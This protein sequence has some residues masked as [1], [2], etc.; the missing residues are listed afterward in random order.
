MK[1]V[2]SI[3]VIV[4]LA[5]VAWL[6]LSNSHRPESQ[7]DQPKT[8]DDVSDSTKSDNAD[9]G[10]LDDFDKTSYSIDELDSIWLVVNKSRPIDLDYV[11]SDLR[12]VN[13]AH[14]AGKSDSEMSMRNVAAV[15]LEEMF[16]AASVDS[17]DLQLGSGYRSSELQNYYYT[18]YVQAYSQ[19]EADKF[20]A[21]PGTS[22]HQ[23]G[24]VADVSGVDE[25]CYLEICFADTAEGRW[26]VDNAH[27]Y[28][29]IV[30]Y[31]KGKENITG[32]Q[33][34]PWHLRY[35]GKELASEL[36]DKNL[37]IEEFFNLVEVDT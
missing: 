31:P 27:L 4:C 30:R 17:I 28:G 7:H 36:L 19:E 21:R 15:A 10:M 12:M 2:I 35:V 23:I 14:K 18:N 6:N 11:P 24:L 26:L 20:S 9:A 29:F 8:I 25:V 16:E 34:E 32:Y 3:V 22:E 13:V 37:T 1:K 33:F 5:L